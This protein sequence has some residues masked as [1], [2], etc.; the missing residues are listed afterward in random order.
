M[1]VRARAGAYI[2]AMLWISGCSSLVKQDAVPPAQGIENATAPQVTP[3]Y[4]GSGQVVE[5]SIRVLPSGWNGY[6]YWL[7]V[8][9][10]PNSDD[11]KEN[12]SILASNDGASW[13]VPPG[14][15][16]PIDLPTF[17]PSAGHLDDG[18]LFYDAASNELWV[19]YIWEDYNGHPVVSHVLR[20][21]SPDGSHWS[22]AVDLVHVPGVEILSPT[23]ET[24]GN[25]Y[26]MWSVNGGTAGCNSTGTT[27][28]YRTS[29]DGVNWS[30]PQ[31][32][33]ISQPGYVIWH[34]EAASVPS[35]QEIWMLLAAYPNGGQCGNTVLFFA[36][37]ADGTNWKTF[38]KAALDVG[39][40]W[41]GGEIYRSALFYESD[42]DLLRIW[43]SA[44]GNSGW[45]MGYTEGNYAAFLK[46]LQQ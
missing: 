4:D 29:G 42:Q 13:I 32:A 2:V 17:A 3:T 30:Q 31:A 27:V 18:D 26:Y 37:S 39:G 41:D 36:K 11:S 20:K 23:I 45:R 44:R 1:K 38:D 5:P 10:Y 35:K 19:Y 14:L 8:Q 25:T 40:N 33:N 28:E 34:I 16:N 12:P 7:V 43:Y 21:S 24:I 9:P 6:E 22:S 46:Q 15:V